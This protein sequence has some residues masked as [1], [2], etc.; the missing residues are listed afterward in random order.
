[1]AANKILTLITGANTGLGYHA[2]SQLAASGKYHVLLGSRDLTKAKTAIQSMAEDKASPTDTSNLEAIQIDVSSDDSIAAAASQV[3]KKY[4]SLD[5]LMLNAG[6]SRATGESP[7]TREQ[8]RQQFDTNVFG[9]A[10]VI[11]TFLPLLRKSTKE[12]GKRIAFTGSSIASHAKSIEQKNLAYA[13]IYR[14]SKSAMQ[15]MM[16]SY[17]A[18]LEGEGFV[19]A[20]SCPGYCGTNLNEFR[21]TKDAKDGAK[22][23]VDVAT[24]PGEKVHGRLVD[25]DGVVAW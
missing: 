25:C 21:G 4:G 17:A 16:A 8:Y 23:L 15:M 2:A 3:E 10:V 22:V 1:M 12:G 6:I 5:I 13:R 9:N 11:D 24:A 7:S 18:E 14:T 19:V 20:A